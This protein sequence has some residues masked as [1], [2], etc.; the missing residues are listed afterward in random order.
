MN[1][2]KSITLEEAV[3]HPDFISCEKEQHLPYYDGQGYGHAMFKIKMRSKKVP[4]YHFT[5]RYEDIFGHVV[6]GEFYY[7]H[8]M[9]PNDV[10]PYSRLTF[11][12]GQQVR[13]LKEYY[14][15]NKESFTLGG[16]AVANY[17]TIVC[18]FYK[19]F[20]TEAMAKQWI[21][22][23]KPKYSQKEMDKALVKSFNIDD[24]FP[25]SFKARF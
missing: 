3:K 13:I 15:V 10:T 20:E 1:K 14:W 7:F 8:I 2:Y 9:N 6:N 23:N 11:E 19:Y 16:R 4:D 18:P 5:Y 22:M 12:S 17:D 25:N 24:F 21:E